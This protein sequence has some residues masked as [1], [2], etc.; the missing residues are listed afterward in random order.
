[1]SRSICSQSLSLACLVTVLV[2]SGCTALDNQYHAF[3]DKHEHDPEL[4]K[5]DDATQGEEMPEAGLVAQDEQAETQREPV[6]SAP[7]D[8]IALKATTSQA[9]NTSTPAKTGDWEYHPDSRDEYLAAQ[10]AST[11]TTTGRVWQDPLITGYQPDST[12]KALNDY[13]A[14]LAMKLMRSAKTLSTNDLIGV[15]SFVRLN[16]SL[17]ETTI[18]GNQLSELLIAEL[19][20]AGMSIV[21]FKIAGGLTVTPHGDLAMTRSGEALSRQ[22]EMDHIL[23]GTLIEEP[24]GV[25]VNARVVSVKTGRVVGSS[26]L[27]VPAF[28]VARLNNHQG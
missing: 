22:L 20:G 18:M 25:R 23:T 15:A 19:Q 26:T 7:V 28:M 16:T 4:M 3:T 10:E 6:K 2:M 12:H 27:V 1:V 13:A 21:D 14:Q 5:A 24:R 8:G 11:E 17:Q 9:I